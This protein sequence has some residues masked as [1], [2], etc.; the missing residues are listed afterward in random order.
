M[1]S[2]N[3]TTPSQLPAIMAQTFADIKHILQPRTK[4]SGT[5]SLPSH[6]SHRMGMQYQQG[7]RLENGRRDCSAIVRLYCRIQ[8]SAEEVSFRAQG[9]EYGA[10]GDH[11][12]GA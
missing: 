9:Q 10:V 2:C 7:H 11:R 1:V 3:P 4:Y 12:F 8:F 5:Q 6:L